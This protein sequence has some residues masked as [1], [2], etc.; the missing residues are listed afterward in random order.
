M[1]CL[2][3]SAQSLAPCFGISVPRVSL[4]NETIPKSSAAIGVGESEIAVASSVGASPAIGDRERKASKM[5]KR[6]RKD[7][8][9]KRGNF[10]KKSRQDR[11]AGDATAEKKEDNFTEWVYTNDNFIKYYQVQ[12]RKRVARCVSAW[13]AHLRK[14]LDLT[15]VIDAVDVIFV[16]VRRCRRRVWCQKPSGTNS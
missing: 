3:P 11:D 9:N 8:R 13:A 12:R 2:Q 14:P 10:S 5:G 4:T 6:G 16:F 1:Q 15:G 7:Y